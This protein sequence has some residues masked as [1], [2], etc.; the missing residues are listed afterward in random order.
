MTYDEII[1]KLA[2]PIYDEL[3]GEFANQDFKRQ[4]M[5]WERAQRIARAALSA[6]RTLAEGRGYRLMVPVEADKKMTDAGQGEATES[7]SDAALRDI[8]RAMLSAA[9]DPTKD[10]RVTIPYIGGGALLG[11]PDPT[12]EPE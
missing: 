10:N 12:K 4:R 2:T 8:F 6:L 1:N 5:Q 11:G 7:N 9:L 3:E